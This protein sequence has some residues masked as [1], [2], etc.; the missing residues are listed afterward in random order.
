MKTTAKRF[1]ALGA[2]VVVAVGTAGLVGATAANAATSSTVLGSIGVS[3]ATDATSGTVDQAIRFTTATGCPAN[4]GAAHATNYASISIDGG[5]PGYTWPNVQLVTTTTVG[6]NHSGAQS[7]PISDTFRNIAAGSGLQVPQGAYTVTLTCQDATATNTSGVF[8]S[9]FTF[10]S[11]GNFT[12][13]APPP[14]VLGTLTPQ[15]SGAN[16]TSLTINDSIA[17]LTSAGCSAVPGVSIPSAHIVINGGSTGHVWSGVDLNT[18]SSS[19]VS[20]SAPFTKNQG[21]TFNGFQTGGGLPTL[22]G[23]YK[24]SEYCQNSTGTVITGVFETN[25][26]FTGAN[27]TVSAVSYAVG[28]SVALTAPATATV[29]S[30]VTLSATVSPQSGGALPAGTVTFSEGGVTV[31]SV[32]N[33]SAGATA[34]ASVTV[35][36]LAVGAHTFNALFATADSGFVGSSALPVT[37]TVKQATPTATVSISPAS[38]N[39][40][41]SVSLTCAV[42]GGVSGPSQVTF[43]YTLPGAASPTTSA[44]QTLTSGS[45]TLN[46]GILSVGNLTLVKCNTIADTN[47][48]AVQSNTV[49]SLS[50]AG[51][52]LERVATEYVDVTV[53]PGTLTL[54]VNGIAPGT[55]GSPTTGKLGTAVNSPGTS[56]TG[57]Y[58][59]TPTAGATPGNTT[60]YTTNTVILPDAALNAAG[61]YIV[62]QGNILPVQA[63]DTRAGDIGY[64]VTGQLTDLVQPTGATHP[65]DTIKSNFVGWTPKFIGSNRV[66]G[67]AT[68]TA[69]G[70]SD[71]GV[72]APAASLGDSSFASEGLAAAK[73]LFTAPAGAS[74]GTVYYG[75]LLNLQAPTTTRDGKYEG[76]LTLT[77]G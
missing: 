7:F 63:V 45:A 20:L 17:W 55:S 11:A 49:A 3:N 15:I 53:V 70:L 19:G 50:I 1:V 41:T 43:T 39:S 76:K 30:N 58:A 21:D 40:T 31:G 44:A 4:D 62:T 73:T 69:A 60:T 29:G 12:V 8:K 74:N 56:G 37:V 67:A 48:V 25:L 22:D 51:Y 68:A 64:S 65:G 46:L 72:A 16:V 5:N 10:D 24:V 27:A 42:T 32:Q 18:P 47:N 38:P 77:A 34:T 59:W 66:T 36:G 57:A 6:V 54:T 26:T 35:S 75:A 14:A 61:T 33:T 28:T 71:G 13:T 2:S 23:T 52:P 9:V